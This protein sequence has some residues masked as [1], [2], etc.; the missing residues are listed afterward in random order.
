MKS[1]KI[2][3]SLAAFLMGLFLTL[4]LLEAG[5][6]IVGA[7]YHKEIVPVDLSS[8]LYQKKSYTILC[9]GNSFTAG[10]EALEGQSYPDDLQRLLDKK[11][12][13]GKNR[14]INFGRV[15]QNTR[16]LLDVLESFIRE[17]NP[18]LIL[19]QTGQPNWWNYYKY[20]DY[21]NRSRVNSEKPRFFTNNILFHSH[22]YR[23]FMSLCNDIINKRD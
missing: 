17:T 22:T 23:L 19:L 11:F 7:V 8:A 15:N 18:N 5:L 13:E 16:E 9:L 21:S 3:H 2:M 6:R 12:G 4:I 14:V 1:H 10:A 20:S